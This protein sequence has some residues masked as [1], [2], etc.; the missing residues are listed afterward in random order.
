MIV[1]EMQCA[2]TPALTSLLLGLCGIDRYRRFC[3]PACD[4]MVCDYVER[5]DWAESVVLGAFDCAARLMG[6]VEIC[7]AGRNA[8][9]ALAV[10]RP[11]RRQ[12]VGRALLECALLHA[13]AM[14]KEA[15]VLTCRVDNLAMRQLAQNTGL[16]VD[17]A[18][19][20]A[21][22]ADEPAASNI[23]YASALR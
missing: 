8:E 11:H 3:R 18:H 23:V 20:S 9:L 12:G 13:R 5:I 16:I 4:R 17:S 21:D 22:D 10:A 15:V 14:G 2:D 6:I 19:A 7:H 1:R